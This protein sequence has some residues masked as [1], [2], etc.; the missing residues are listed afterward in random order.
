MRHSRKISDDRAALELT[1][2]ARGFTR[3]F[4]I[5]HRDRVR[6][7]KYYCQDRQI[8]NQRWWW[9][10]IGKNLAARQNEK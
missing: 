8:K 10:E 6:F 9:N 5:S 1:R 3:R 7:L 4:P 2:L